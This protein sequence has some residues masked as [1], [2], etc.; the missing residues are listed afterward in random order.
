M[1]VVDVD[2]EPDASMVRRAARD[3]HTVEGVAVRLRVTEERARSL[4]EAHREDVEDVAPDLDG[5]GFERA[6]ESE[7]GGA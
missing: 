1:T 6:S 5:A 3:A 2:E 7:R 4:L